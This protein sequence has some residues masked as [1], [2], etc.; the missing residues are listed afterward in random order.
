M[1]DGKTGK[2]RSWQEIAKEVV[3]EKDNKKLLELTR[4]LTEAVD[5][6]LAKP[7]SGTTTAERSLRSTQDVETHKDKDFDKLPKTGTHGD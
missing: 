6:E 7:G 4:E 3:D 5:G 2:G 1:L